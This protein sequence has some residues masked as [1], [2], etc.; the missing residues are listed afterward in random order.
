MGF[1][2]AGFEMWVLRTIMWVLTRVKNAG[3]G[4]ISHAGFENPHAGFEDP[5]AGFEN[6][7]AG[8]TIMWVLNPENPLLMHICTTQGDDIPSSPS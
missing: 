3:F 6:P 2:N 1:K 7:S 4:S 5:S 8:F